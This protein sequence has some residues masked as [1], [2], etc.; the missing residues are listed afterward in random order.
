[1]ASSH[2][3]AVQTLLHDLEKEFALKD[4]GD[5]HYFLGIEVTHSNQGLVLTQQGYDI[6]LLKRVDM[7][8][9]KLVATPLSSTEKLSKLD[10]DSLGPEDLTRYRSVVGALQYL[11]L[12]RPDIAFS[13]NKVCQF[14]HSPTTVH[15]L[16]LRDF[17][18][19]QWHLKGRSHHKEISFFIT[20][21]FCIC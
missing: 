4:L 18:L 8:S 19:Y 12:T 20:Q 17:T 14:L 9:S 11:T 21:C 15:W 7:L 16:R 13:V 3:D 6:E 5:L 2:S 10:G 1:M